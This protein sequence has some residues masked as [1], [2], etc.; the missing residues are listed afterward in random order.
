[1]GYMR[2]LADHMAFARKLTRLLDLRFSVFGFRFGI[3]PLLDLIPGF[4]N[5]A[6]TITSL[7]LFWLGYRLRVPNHVYLKMLVNIGIDYIL[8]SVPVLGIVGDALYRSN[9][10]NLALL[11]LYYDPSVLEGEY[12]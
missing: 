8:G 9:V 3:D 2:T 1:M 4:G 11:D 10:R 12:V 6:T 5:A 7:Y